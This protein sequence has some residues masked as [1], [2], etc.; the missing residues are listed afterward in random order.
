MVLPPLRIDRI[1]PVPDNWPAACV[2]GGADAG[3]DAHA[4][5]GAAMKSGQSL[6]DQGQEFLVAKEDE[7][8]PDMNSGVAHEEFVAQMAVGGS[9]GDVTVVVADQQVKAGTGGCVE[10]VSGEAHL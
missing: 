8:A 9:G 3:A 10:D 7:M 1:L 4:D 6:A 2:L 5:S